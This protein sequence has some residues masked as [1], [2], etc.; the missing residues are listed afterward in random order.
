MGES[1]VSW[2]YQVKKEVIML[3]EL[4]YYEANTAFGIT[5]CVNDKKI[6]R[7]DIENI[8]YDTDTEKFIL[9][10]WK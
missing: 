8:V 3:K 2:G 9:F 4:C 6:D 5:V 10:F 7:K 1:S